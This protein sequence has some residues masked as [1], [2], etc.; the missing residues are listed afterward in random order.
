MKNLVL[1]SALALTACGPKRQITPEPAW[2]SEEGQE[3]LRLE[4]V[5]GLLEEGAYP[6][7][8]MMIAT[9]RERDDDDPT[10]DLYQGIALNRTGLASEAERILQAYVESRPRDERG[11]RELGLIFA[12]TQRLDLSAEALQ[13]AVDLH[14]SDAGTWNNLGYV[15]MSARRYDEAVLALQ[16]AVEL[17]GSQLRYRNNLGFALAGAGA[18]ADALQAFMSAAHPADAHANLALA[19]E[20]AGDGITALDHYERALEYDPTHE[21]SREALERLHTEEV[22]P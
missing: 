6:E 7:A 10:L 13:H 8:L 5:D 11:W 17:D 16:R 21:T 22:L 19:L 4:L 15:L 20:L 3:R 12:D 18:L 1:L 14:D 9:A 2:R